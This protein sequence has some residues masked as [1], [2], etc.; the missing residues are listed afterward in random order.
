MEPNCKHNCKNHDTG[1]KTG[2][3]SVRVTD[4]SRSEAVTV[5]RREPRKLLFSPTFTPQPHNDM[6][7]AVEKAAEAV[8]EAARRGKPANLIKI[9]FGQIRVFSRKQP[10]VRFFQ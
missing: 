9:S 10:G 7:A 2:P 8:A 6:V 3:A 5:G 4:T 1:L